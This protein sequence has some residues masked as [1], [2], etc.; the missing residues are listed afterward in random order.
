MSRSTLSILWCLCAVAAIGSSHLPAEE[1]LP[2]GI[3]LP[4][5]WPPD[6]KTFPS[7]DP[8]PP[9]LKQP[10]RVIRI[11]TGRQLFVDDFLIQ[12]T[13]MDRT[14][15]RPV[16]HPANPVLKP[17]QP[18][19]LEGYGPFAA[20]YSGGVWF[21]PQDSLFK[22][23][24]MGGY[25]RHLCLAT[26]TD[27][28]HWDRPDLDV[29]DGTNIVLRGGAPESN[30]VL[31]D[32][33]E[34]DPQRRFK[35]LYFQAGGQPA[36][37]MNYRYSADGIHWSD[38][39][40]RSSQC[41][42]RTTVFF[43][44]FRKKY[45]FLIRA[46]ANQSGRAKRYWETDDLNDA[47]SVR[48]PGTGANQALTPLWVRSALGRDFT[49]PEISDMPQ[50]YQLDAMA[51][52]SLIVGLFAIHRGRYSM[53]SDGRP[54]QPGRPKC[55]ELMVGYS[56]DGFHWYRPDMST[57]LGV[58]E[59]RGSWR[60]GNIQPVGSLGL[61]VGDNLHFYVSARQGDPDLTNQSEWIHDANASTGLAVL[62]RD[63]FASMDADSE[64]RTLTT[65]T[66]QFTG[67]HLFVN[68]DVPDGELRVEVLDEHGQPLEPFTL[69]NCLPVQTNDTL[70]NVT[71]NSATDLSAVAGK[72][73][74]FRFHL[75]NGRL[76]SFWVSSSKTGASGG[77][78]LGGGP[79][80]VAQTDTVG[81]P[82]STANRTPF[83]R[84]TL[85]EIV[86]TETNQDTALVTLDGSRSL[87]LDGTL[88]RYSWTLEGQ[89]LAT[90]KRAT[91]SLPAGT[92]TVTL[93]VTDNQQAQGHADVTVTVPS[94]HKSIIPQKQLVMWLKADAVTGI[95]DGNPLERWNDSSP[96]QLFSTQADPA[97]QP[98]WLK[99]AING[100]PSV[101]FDG[102]DDCLMVDH[103]PGLLYSYFNST[104]FAVVR[105]KE[106]GAIISH[107]HTNLT[108]SPHNDGTLSYSTA[109]QNFET[110]EYVWPGIRSRQSAA[111]PAGRPCLLAMRRGS[112]Q[113]GGTAL[114]VN[115]H[116][117]DDQVAI[118]YHLMN[119]ANGFVGAGY[120]GQ[121]QYWSGEIAEV[122]LYGRALDDAEKQ[123]VEAYLTTKYGLSVN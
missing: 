87:D 72:P 58:S 18:H 86:P 79:G 121:R 17:E 80:F 111:V 98:V 30:S 39:Q 96:S 60:W 76:F 8:T 41:G 81:R 91:V 54:I 49:R 55:N 43:N 5:Q 48:W 20:P 51:Y 105:R 50:L 16:Y 104:L 118:D 47:E 7:N 122:V 74:R 2:N 53:R 56:R 6:R 85:A 32:L 70:H 65:R 78:V 1:I 24:Y 103:C 42:D 82:E 37:A 44:P 73:V 38:P 102:V 27:G 29:V 15:H 90:G 109:Y 97:R 45:V 12:S 66:V 92:H 101:R 117:D 31:M 93:T 23:W 35:Y 57:F 95:A 115:G 68:A 34:P 46:K 61:V 28:I 62:R 26:S 120:R 21:D 116:R 25:T 63:G 114:F 3:V 22:M 64:S 123:Q 11:D 52:E 67:T 106:G 77:Y 84:A 107:G 59:Q 88:E 89:P 94:P 36:W 33:H 14:Y 9:Y 75:R 119:S 69:K 10:P 113:K 40:W 19:E 4:D 100:Q 13:D 110:G 112:N 83:A 71:W 108:V 99:N